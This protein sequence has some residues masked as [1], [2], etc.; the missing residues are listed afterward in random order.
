MEGPTG[1]LSPGPDQKLLE[2]RD[3]FS[4]SCPLYLGFPSIQ[5][6][7]S[8]NLG[9]EHAATVF[10]RRCDLWETPEESLCI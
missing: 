5:S 6:H 10:A 2:S 8:H 3:E 4:N 1:G 7:M 9:L